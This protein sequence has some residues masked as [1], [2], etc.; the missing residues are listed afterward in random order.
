M[1]V[2]VSSPPTPHITDTSNPIC[3]GVNPSTVAVNMTVFRNEFENLNVDVLGIQNLNVTSFVC[4]NGRME[5]LEAKRVE[6]DLRQQLR[7]WSGTC[8]HGSRRKEK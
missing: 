8:D 3:A 2:R 4:P 1:T 6:P 5:Q 7:Y